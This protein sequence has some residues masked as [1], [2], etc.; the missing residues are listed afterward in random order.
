[1]GLFNWLFGKKLE[2]NNEPKTTCPRCLGK[3]NV[4]FDDIAR[5]RKEL[6]W[7]P[8]KCA[9]CKGIGQVPS[10]LL[11]SVAFDEVYITANLS[12]REIEKFKSKDK[13]AIARAEERKFVTNDFVNQFVEAYTD[14]NKSVEDYADVIIKQHPQYQLSK[15][16]RTLHRE[17]L[18]VYLKKVI[19]NKGL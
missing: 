16:K 8:G 19:V 6:H 14:G 10:S 2:E 12:D 13:G 4:D 1:M 18:I 3:G 11:E 7:L 5:M 17:K 15:V 9:Y